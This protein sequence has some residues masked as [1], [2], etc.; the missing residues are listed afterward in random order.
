MPKGPP[1][2]C[3]QAHSGALRCSVY[4]IIGFRVRLDSPMLRNRSSK[5][6]HPCKV[7]YA[8]TRGKRSH[9]GIGDAETIPTITSS[10]NLS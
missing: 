4:I 9:G 5:G 10:P 3:D 6:L 7:C 8:A 2:L 1:G